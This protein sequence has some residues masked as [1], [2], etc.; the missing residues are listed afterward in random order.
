[1]GILSSPDFDTTQPADSDSVKFGAGWI[2]DL[3]SRLQQF[4]STLF[5]LETG[6]FRD[7][8]VRSASL[9]AS[10]VT[11]GTYS[12]VKVNAK[13]LVTEGQNPTAQQTA[14]PY[15]A[16]F[17]AGGAYHYETPGN[18]V[19]N[20]AGTVDSVYLGNYSYASAPLD[21]T[22]TPAGG[23]NVTYGSF[24]FAPPAGVTRVKA[25]IIGGG[26]GAWDDSTTIASSSTWYGGGGGECVETV[27]WDLDGTGTQQLK[28][29]VGKGG[30]TA[31]S[32]GSPGFDGCPSQVY[33][34]ASMYATA[35][36]GA[37]A[38]SS[39][40]GAS[41]GGSSSNSLGVIRSVGRGGDSK[42]AG[43]TGSAYLQFGRGAGTDLAADGLVILE[44]YQ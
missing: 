13:G 29:C 18:V 1:M 2:R 30:A 32:S 3:K 35:G 33:L 36:H 27:F 12:Q 5:N 22:L 8:V 34:T 4:C 26:G 39:A 42:Q 43:L 23:S 10:G 25:T 11:P 20:S 44:W 14:Q 15:R 24:V 40:G 28:V 21:A 31:V 7:N 38:S 16:V 6:D 19:V 37:S 41:Y 9:T 17:S